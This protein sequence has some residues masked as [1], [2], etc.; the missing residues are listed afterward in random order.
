MLTQHRAASRGPLGFWTLWGRIS[1]SCA[2][3]DAWKSPCGPGMEADA[4]AMDD[5]LPGAPECGTCTRDLPQPGCGWEALLVVGDGLPAVNISGPG[6]TAHTSL[7][8]LCVW[9]GGGGRG[10]P[11]QASAHPHPLRCRQAAGTRPAPGRGRGKPEAE[12][13]VALRGQSQAALPCPPAPPPAGDS[14]RPPRTLSPSRRSLLLRAVPLPLPTDAGVSEPGLGIVLGLA[15]PEAGPGAGSPQ[16][17]LAPG[18][19][20]ARFLGLQGVPLATE[21]QEPRC[22]QSSWEPAA[23]GKGKGPLLYPTLREG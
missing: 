7:G 4:V 3:R 10:C 15:D 22:G 20:C 6:T 17:S 13:S 18:P 9:G 23:P 16:A 19:F 11:G 5:V 21:P 14:P 8:S 1:D 2:S 12:C